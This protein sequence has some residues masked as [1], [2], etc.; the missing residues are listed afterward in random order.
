MEQQLRALKG[1]HYKA[2]A[3]RKRELCAQTK[4]DQARRENLAGRTVLELAQRGEIKP[5]QLRTWLNAA[6]TDPADRALFDQL[7]GPT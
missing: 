2:E 3:K 5:A 7:E 4:R 6:L 1:R